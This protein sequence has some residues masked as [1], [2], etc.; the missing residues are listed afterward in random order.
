MQLPATQAVDSKDCQMSVRSCAT[1]PLC[2]GGHCGG[3]FILRGADSGELACAV[4][5][6]LALVHNG[7]VTGI[8]A[9]SLHCGRRCQPLQDVTS[10]GQYLHA[11]RSDDAST[12][13]CDRYATT[14]CN[15]E[16]GANAEQC[17]TVLL[18][19]EA[20]ERRG[21]RIADADAG[22]AG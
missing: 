6:I 18:R 20:E 3:R 8:L 2:P 16:C 13:L 9:V 5:Y 12:Q 14:P 22:A 19:R 21:N 7:G 11:L 17:G 15:T 1:T 10:L 4:Y